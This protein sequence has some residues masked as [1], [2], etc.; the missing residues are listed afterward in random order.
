MPGSQNGES[1]GAISAISGF[2]GHNNDC[3]Q[4]IMKRVPAVPLHPHVYEVALSQL[5]GGS[6]CDHT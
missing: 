6:G 2:F 5:K 1:D 4:S 3:Q